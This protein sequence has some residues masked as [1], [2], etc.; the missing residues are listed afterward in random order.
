MDLTGWL[1]LGSGAGG[2]V[3]AV[4]VW[5]YHRGREQALNDVELWKAQA[6]RLTADIAEVQRVSVEME[7]R[8]AAEYAAIRE[9]NAKQAEIMEGMARAH[10]DL[11]A[12]YL[13]GLLR[14]TAAPAAGSPAAPVS[15]PAPASPAPGSAGRG[16]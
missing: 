10:P 6:A 8:R 7:A 14:A 4:L 15:Q 1:A 5:Y 3:L 13:R 2:L 12:E 9:W 11:S 16:P